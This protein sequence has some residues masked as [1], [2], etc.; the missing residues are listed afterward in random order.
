[1]KRSDIKRYQIG[2]AC[3]CWSFSDRIDENIS[4]SVL[5]LFQQ[6]NQ[7]TVRK[8]L[9][10]KDLVPSYN[11][12]AV[13]YDPVETS[14]DQLTSEVERMI[15]HYDAKAK[16]RSLPTE[17]TILHSIPVVYEGEDLERVSR[18]NDLTLADVIALHQ[19]PEY[20]VAM[21]GFLPYFPYLIG[22]DP[23]LETPRLDSPRNR[24]P[25]GAVAIGGA[26]AGVYP[27]ESPGG[28]N[29]LGLTDPELLKTIEPGDRLKFKGVH[30]L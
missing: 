14:I 19:E 24:V 22:L 25:A 13:H 10:I 16:E 5:F 12:L 20:V 21:I 6:L 30:S 26:Q 8:S 17:Q 29:I 1:M 15:E 7:P 11:A 23:K 18:L 27:Q 28:W 3:L 4:Q 2:D 9:L